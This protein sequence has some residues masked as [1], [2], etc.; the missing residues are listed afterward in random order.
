MTN[1]KLS[2]AERL[3]AIEKRRA[4]I[5]KQLLKKKR[6]M[7]HGYKELMAPAPSPIGRFGSFVANA[8]TIAAIADGALMGYRLFRKIKRIF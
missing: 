2:Q 5:A 4:L 7:R 6:S 1:N 8:G 3:A